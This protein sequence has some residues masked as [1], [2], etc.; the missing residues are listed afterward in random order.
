MSQ[1]TSRKRA[2][3]ISTA[4]LFIG[5]A[6]VTFLHAWWPGIMLVIGI[7]LALRQFLLGHHF[8]TLMSLVIFCGVFVT[9]QFEVGWEVLLPVLFI[10]AAIYILLREFQEN[11]EHPEDVEEEDLNHEIEEISEEE[12]PQK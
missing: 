7:P 2:S 12:H 10:L 4:L 1:I 8:D 3:A 9:A 11:R 5:L 6:I